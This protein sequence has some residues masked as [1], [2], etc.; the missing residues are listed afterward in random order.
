M[1]NDRDGRRRRLGAVTGAFIGL[2][3]GYPSSFGATTTVFIVPVALAFD[4]ART[5]PVGIYT[6]SMIG[7]ALAS[8]GLGRMVERFGEARTAI[9][10]GIGLALGMAGLSQMNGS[11]PTA[12][13]LG[14]LIGIFGAGTGV[15]VYVSVLPKWFNAHLGRALGLAVLGQS[16]GMTLMPALATA[17]VSTSGWRSAYL[18][19]AATQLALTAVAVLVLRWVG[20]PD[21]PL[22]HVEGRPASTGMT[23]AQAIRTHHFWL[24]AAAIFFATLGILG[25]AVSLF[26]IAIDRGIPPHILAG[27]TA[28]LGVGTALGRLG[29]GFLLDRIDARWVGAMTF[30]LGGV[31]I[32]CLLTLAPGN[33]S[34]ALYGPAALIGIALGA[35]SDVLAY[36]ARRFFG[37]AHYPSIYN[38]LLVAYYLGAIAGPLSVSLLFNLF[39]LGWQPI[40]FTAASC[41]LASG[42]F[43]LL[44]CGPREQVPR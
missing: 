10:G 33:G 26:P 20:S 1:H 43:A 38:H 5:V 25:A 44:P 16:A 15:G 7:M 9:C 14:L 4:W 8:F 6:S 24:L 23:L 30:L 12:L 37:L 27:M 2:S 28:I 29:S 31:G 42:G 39:P 21:R 41:L 17:I 35:E 40:F 32:L 22:I 3:A 13:F 18:W 34:L 19:L 11:I 36:F